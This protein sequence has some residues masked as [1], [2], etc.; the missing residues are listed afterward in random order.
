MQLC[1]AY[2]SFDQ[3]L[4][5]KNDSTEMNK[6]ESPPARLNNRYRLAEWLGEGGMGIVYRAHDEVL[7]RDVAIKFLL[8]QYIAS[9]EAGERF[10]REA[11]AVARLSHPTS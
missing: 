3:P 4:D 5:E 11:R 10:M 1:A 9:A 6:H 8:P 7:D 2:I